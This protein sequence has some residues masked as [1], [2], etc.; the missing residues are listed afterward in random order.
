M[1]SETSLNRE[2]VICER[3]A[4]GKA[5]LCFLQDICKILQ[6]KV[7]TDTKYYF[8]F[9]K[10]PIYRSHQA[11]QCETRMGQWKL[12]EAQ[13]PSVTAESVAVR[14]L[15]PARSR[16]IPSL[17]VTTLPPSSPERVDVY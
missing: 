8:S 3:E 7:C 17:P 15:S 16:L 6:I 14:T 2:S 12:A 4:I 13:S 9:V 11:T 10:S 1:N 5:Y